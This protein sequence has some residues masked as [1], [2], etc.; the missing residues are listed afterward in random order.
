MVLSILPPPLRQYFGFLVLWPIFAALP[1]LGL[2]TRRSLSLG[3]V[4]LS[5]FIEQFLA[6]PSRPRRR[7]NAVREDALRRLGCHPLPHGP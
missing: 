3:L 6:T 2:G 7:A 5:I 4:Q 1:F